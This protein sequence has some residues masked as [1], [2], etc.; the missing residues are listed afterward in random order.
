MATCCNLRSA[1][2]TSPALSFSPGLPR[3]S[4]GVSTTPLGEETPWYTGN[5]PVPSQL[6]YFQQL[7]LY[8]ILLLCSSVSF[9]VNSRSWKSLLRGWALFLAPRFWERIV[10]SEAMLSS[11]ILSMKCTL[12]TYYWLSSMPDAGESK[13]KRSLCPQVTQGLPRDTNM[14]TDDSSTMGVLWSP[15]DERLAPWVLLTFHNEKWERHR[16]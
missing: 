1:G 13:M 10:L 3:T 9:F 8:V 15:G 7:C 5:A 6:C 4:S 14:S 11:S 12:H 2:L 16:K